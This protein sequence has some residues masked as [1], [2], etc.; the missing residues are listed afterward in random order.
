MRLAPICTVAAIL[1]YAGCTGITNPN[2]IVFPATNVSFKAQVEPYFSL[3]CNATGCHDGSIN[4]AGGVDL[5][6]WAG[7]RAINVTRANDTGSNLVLV[8]YA[9][10]PH[11][12]QFPANDNQRSG[13]KQWVREGAQN[14]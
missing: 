3:A 8:M 6:S 5:T 11:S 14:N 7:V 13:I 10:L 1:A 12:G 9:E 4:T 2:D